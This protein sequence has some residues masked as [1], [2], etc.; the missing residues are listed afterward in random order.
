MCK[1]VEPYEAPYKLLSQDDI[2]YIQ[3]ME[4]CEIFFNTNY[5]INCKPEYCDAKNWKMST[6]DAVHMKQ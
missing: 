3:M 5:Y 1:T 2:H 4:L 6:T